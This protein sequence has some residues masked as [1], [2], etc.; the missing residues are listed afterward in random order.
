MWLV[1]IQ[2]LNPATKRSSRSGQRCL[3]GAGIAEGR[4]IM[5]Y[6]VIYH[7]S[8]FRLS[9]KMMRA[10]VSRYRTTRNVAIT[11]PTI[12]CQ[13]D[14][15]ASPSP[16][17]CPFLFPGSL[18]CA[19]RFERVSTPFRIYDAFHGGKRRTILQS[20]GQTDVPPLF[21]CRGRAAALTLIK[22]NDCVNAS[23]NGSVKKSPDC[24]PIADVASV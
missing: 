5:R 8:I 16:G 4:K 14:E 19:T 6:W 22:S 15:R 24:F 20:V 13:F 21:V 18:T 3:R 11:S 2:W 1:Q 17:F 7:R 10:G 12:Y 23:V 9:E